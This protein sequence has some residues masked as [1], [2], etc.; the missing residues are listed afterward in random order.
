[1]GQQTHTS[2]HMLDRFG[3]RPSALASDDEPILSTIVGAVTP[4]GGADDSVAPGDVL[5]RMRAAEEGAVNKAAFVAP[6]AAA[7]PL[8]MLPAEDD[9]SV[10]AGGGGL[11]RAGEP[12]TAVGAGGSGLCDAGE[13]RS[14]PPASSAATAAAT[15]ASSRRKW[16]A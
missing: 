2:E 13:F 9:E 4:A 5:R 15:L 12:V 7:E 16:M 10:A 8:T 6:A 3:C 11:W 14:L 1:M